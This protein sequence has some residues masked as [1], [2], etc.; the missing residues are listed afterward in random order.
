MKYKEFC[1]A[2]F[3]ILINWKYVQSFD[4]PLVDSKWLAEHSCDK[5]VR[6]IAV[7]RST[8]V[9]ESSHI[10]CSVYTNFYSDGW[11]ETRGGLPLQLPEP[12]ALEKI[13]GSLGIGRFCSS[14]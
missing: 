8:S 6:V 3:I 2:F 4:K 1:I 9:F 5:D 10:P 14:A 13:I 12:H 7:S 11:R